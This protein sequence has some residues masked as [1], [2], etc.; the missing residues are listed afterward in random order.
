MLLLFNIGF[1]MWLLLK[2]LCK[3]SY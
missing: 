2:L 1:L 3:W